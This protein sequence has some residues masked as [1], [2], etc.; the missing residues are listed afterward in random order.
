MFKR[1]LLASCLLAFSVSPFAN[2][3]WKFNIEVAYMISDWNGVIQVLFFE[4]GA[5]YK[6]CGETEYYTFNMSEPGA[7]AMNSYLLAAYASKRKVSVIFDCS[8][9]RISAVR[10][11]RDE[12]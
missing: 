10:L 2:P 8:S 1:F 9:N 6:A 7:Q 3:F 4:N 11:E 12:T 5:P